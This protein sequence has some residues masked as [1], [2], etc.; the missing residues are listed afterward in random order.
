MATVAPN[1][2]SPSAMPRPIPSPPPVTTATRPVRRMFDGSMVTGDELTSLGGADAKPRRG[3]PDDPLVFEF[4]DLV[5]A[6]PE[7]GKHFVVV[8][9][10]KR[11]G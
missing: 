3:G 6:E 8:L 9:P 10:E 4:F 5:I 11:R 2:A 7:P 1:T